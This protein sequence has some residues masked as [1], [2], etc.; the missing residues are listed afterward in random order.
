[1]EKVNLIEGDLWKIAHGGIIEALTLLVAFLQSRT[2]LLAKEF[3][4][5][6]PLF[7]DEDDPQTWE[8]YMARGC[9]FCVGSLIQQ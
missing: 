3:A 6:I 1:M 7:G 4:E 5:S 9:P 8:D 2:R